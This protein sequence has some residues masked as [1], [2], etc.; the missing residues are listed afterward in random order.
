MFSLTSIHKSIFKMYSQ[1]VHL[2]IIHGKI[3]FNTKKTSI[4]IAWHSQSK[5]SFNIHIFIDHVNEQFRN[6]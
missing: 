6:C 2:T 5:S 4:Y 1:T 3:Q